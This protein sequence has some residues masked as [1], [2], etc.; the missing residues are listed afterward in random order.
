MHVLASNEQP[1]AGLSEE[2]NRAMGLCGIPGMSVAV[3]YKGKL[4]YVEGFGKR[5]EKDPFTAEV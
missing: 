4:I 3:Q 1:L 5:N 2:L